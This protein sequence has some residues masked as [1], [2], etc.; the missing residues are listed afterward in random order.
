MTDSNTGTV[1]IGRKTVGKFAD[2]DAMVEA[3]RE[4]AADVGLSYG[5]LDQLTGLGE[6]GVGKYL[7][8]LRVRHLSVTS[9]NS[10]LTGASSAASRLARAV[11]ASQPAR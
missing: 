9:S 8:D 10:V 5:L 3:I 11:P 6:G 7:A 2:Y 4:R 1:Q